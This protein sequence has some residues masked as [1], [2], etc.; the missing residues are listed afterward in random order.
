MLVGENTVLGAMPK[1]VSEWPPLTQTLAVQ[2]PPLNVPLVEYVTFCAPATE[3]AM[4]TAAA[5]ERARNQLRT[6][7]LISGCAGE[8]VVG[9][10][11]EP[12]RDHA[13]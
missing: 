8:M 9:L 6:K 7:V 3:A 1:N 13:R 5:T 11:R 2:G 4:L 12:T 10:W